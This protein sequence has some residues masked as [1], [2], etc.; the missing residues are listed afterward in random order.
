MSADN[1]KE[2][3]KRTLEQLEE[4]DDCD[5]GPSLSDAIIQPQKK[6]KVLKFERTYLENIPS[7]DFY[8]KSYMHRDTINFVALSKTNFI[9]TA[10]ADGN[11][12]M[13]SKKTDEGIEFVKHFKCH[14]SAITDLAV[15]AN[16]EFCSTS[17]KDK[18][19]KIFDII[20]FDMI[21]MLR[22]SYIPQC[23]CWVF[24]AGDPIPAIAVAEKNT[25]NIHIYDCK[26]SGEILHTYDSLHFNPV[27]LMKFNHVYGTAISVDT[28][29]MVEYWTGPKHDYVFPKDVLWEFKTETDLYE[30]VKSKTM[31]LGLGISHDGKKFATICKDRKIRIFNFLTGKMTKVLN[32]SLQRFADLQQNKQQISSMEFGKRMA[33]EKELE[34]SEAYNYCNIIFDRS[35][36]F[37]F[38]A[39]MLG[40][41]V[42]NLYTNECVREIGRAENPRFLQLALFQGGTNPS[43]SSLTVEMQ[44]SDNPA[45]NTIQLDPILFCTAFKKN[46]FYLFSSREPMDKNEEKDRDIFNEK[47]TNEEI[48]SAAQDVSYSRTS[49][50]AVIHTTMGD[51]HITL[52]HK[53]C[54]KTVENFCVHSRN[55]YYNGHLVHRVIK[56]FM[57]Q[58]GDPTGNGTGGESIWGGSFEDEFHRNL[59]HDAPFTVSMANCGPDTNGSQFFITLVPTPWLDRKHTVF[60]RVTKGMDVVQKISLVKTNKHNDKPFDDVNIISVTVK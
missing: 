31:P 43:K 56:G 35:G 7:S 48:V 46:R 5:I 14:S 2:A 37:L 16:G 41:K 9:L 39:T 53:E 34:K 1:P 33:T 38:Y 44:A 60:G 50:N 28:K 47:P 21:N 27:V 10:S 25:P 42:V 6:K 26:G 22:V 11:L 19:I 58:M 51:I 8:E 23:C 36:Y 40:I 49:D 12:K 3:N 52:F 54:P 13:W 17:S 15:S 24:A 32:E 59:K 29:G 4:S 57:I 55:G 18:V 45:L 30:F 20:N